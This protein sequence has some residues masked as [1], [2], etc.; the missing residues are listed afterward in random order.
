MN[1]RTLILGLVFTFFAATD[2]PAVAP[3]TPGAAPEAV[4]LLEF[5]SSLSGKH[6]LTGQHNFPNTKDASTVRVTEIYGKEPA[7]FGQD[8]GFAAPGDQDA[9]AARPEIVEEVKRQYARGATIALCWHAVPPTADEPV[10]FH[11][12][13]DASPTNALAS[14]QGR[15]TDA[16]WRDLL[17][18]GTDLYNRW[19]AQ[20]DVIAGWLQKLQ[21][22]R[23]PVLWR[24]Y[25]EMNGRWFWWGGRPGTNGTSALYRQLFDR[26][27]NHHHLTN[28][29]WVWSVD[30]PGI[31]AGTFA[32]FYPGENYFDVAALD[33]YRN[34][35]QQSYYTNLLAL[36]RGKPVTLAEV[37]P[38]PA[39]EIL[40]RQ[41]LWTWWMSWAGGR[42]GTNAAIQALFNDPRCWSL[43]DPEY[44]K[45]TAPIRAASGLPSMPR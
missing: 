11:P 37:G 8:F 22:A 41:P 17:T 43:R 24:P 20:V 38:P 32:E 2:I 23:V 10:T 4:A 27:V 28:L 3:V 34:D 36:A 45:A 5:I 7:L 44:L 39:V 26:F 15:L 19:C 9:A 33:V 29:V 6:I 42:I 30:R 16:Q 12:K 31:N 18:P 21:E 40:D 35:F 1:L 25:H 13:R 14:V